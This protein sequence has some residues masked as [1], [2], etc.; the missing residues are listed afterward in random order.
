MAEFTKAEAEAARGLVYAQDAMAGE[1]GR[2]APPK[3]MR[4][5]RKG[6]E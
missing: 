3:A 2:G 5:L 4:K 1:S 6:K